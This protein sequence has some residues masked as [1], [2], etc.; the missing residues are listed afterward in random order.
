LILAVVPIVSQPLLAGFLE[1][2]TTGLP[3]RWAAT[4]VFVVGGDVADAGVEPVGVVVGL[5]DLEFGP[6]HGRVG[7][8]HQVWV[9]V[10]DGLGQRLDLECSRY[11]GQ[12]N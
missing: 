9:V 8:G 6:Q 12:Q 11:C 7:D 10:L 2:L 1:S 5:D 3:G 4:G